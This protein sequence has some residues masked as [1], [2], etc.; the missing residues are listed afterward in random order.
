M[1]NVHP[2]YCTFDNLLQKR[3]FR[4]PNYQRAYSWEKEQRQALFSDIKKLHEAGESEKHHFMA[5]IVCLRTTK[6]A[7]LNG[8]D[9][10]LIF[11]VVD[12]QQRITTLIIM[13]KALQKRLSIEQEQQ[14]AAEELQK[15]LVKKD[16]ERLILLQTNHDSSNI[17]R[18]YLSQGEIHSGENIKTLGEKNIIDAIKDCEKYVYTWKKDLIDLLRLI[19]NKLGFI[20]YELQ[21][22][23]S[24]Y[25]IF[26]VLNSRGL[27]VDPLDK[28]KSLLMATAFEKKLGQEV[29][30]ELQKIWA[31]IYRTMSIK[32]VRGDEV[33][34]FA[35][36]LKASKN[37]NFLEEHADSSPSKIMSKRKALEY[38][39]S[40]SSEHPN[41]VQ[42]F[43]SFILDVANYLVEAYKEPSIR[44]ITSIS[45][46]RL[47]LVAIRLNKNIDGDPEKLIAEW[48]KTTFR[49][50]GLA[51]KDSRTGASEYTRLACKIYRNSI[52]FQ[53]ICKNLWRI[54][55]KHSLEDFSSIL[56][57]DWYSNWSDQLKY[58]FY[59]YELD[60]AKKRGL[61]FDRE[62]WSKIWDDT[63][64]RSIEHI[65]PQKYENSAWRGILG[66]DEEKIKK[67]INRIGNLLVLP[68]KENSKIGNSVF[69]DKKKIYKEHSHFQHIKD[70]LSYEHWTFSSI[71]EREKNLS[72]WAAE[73]WKL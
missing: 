10:Y 73:Y 21:D 37:S 64:L 39:R 22:Q 70:V 31:N 41:E 29:M 69:A 18:Q 52:G 34:R 35:A 49:I 36:T 33:V 47:L 54:G 7:E 42:E 46:A 2:Q 13:L 5:T 15:L 9:E 14:N 58:F 68:P 61:S 50:Y 66:S 59:C 67:T 1:L 12:G 23:N 62:T 57:M 56:S 4:I 11:D 63:S 53:D 44:A 24:A 26:E 48:E 19:K 51:R 43:S 30:D 28:C 25:T 72:K 45:Q 20:F 27:E 8:A 40:K 6:K 16:K 65:H 38:F 32:D 17:F 3:L 55:N 60:Y 71:E